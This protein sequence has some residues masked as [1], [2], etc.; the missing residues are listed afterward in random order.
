MLGWIVGLLGCCVVGLFCLFVGLLGC[1]VV[2]LLGCWVVGLSF[3][4]WLVGFLCSWVV[5]FWGFGVVL[6]CWV[7]GLLCCWVVGLLGCLVAGLLGCCPR[8]EHRLLASMSRARVRACLR[9]ELTS[10]HPSA[11]LISALP[12]GQNSHLGIHEQSSFPD[13]RAGLTS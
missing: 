7:L 2:G 9:A 5:G 12:G 10:W 1:W 6:G 3:G 13:A 8:A 4:C 11:E